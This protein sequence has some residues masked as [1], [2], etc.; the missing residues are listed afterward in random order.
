MQFGSKE[1]LVNGRMIS[2]QIREFCTLSLDSATTLSCALEEL[3]LS[4]LAHG[5]VVR[6]ARTLADLDG[7]DAIEPQPIAEAVGYRTLDRLCWE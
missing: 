1:P 6:V 7:T 5:N 2:A 4:A 3:G